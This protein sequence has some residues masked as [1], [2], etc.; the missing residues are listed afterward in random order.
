VVVD[1]W[2]PWCAPCRAFG[3]VLAAASERHPEV[4]FARI[5]SDQEKDLRR[6]FEVESL[7]TLVVVRDHVLLLNRPGYVDAKA[8]DRLVS[9]ALE[10]DLEVVRHGSGQ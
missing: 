2:A 6:A 3:P 4:G 5:D 10:V 9:D 1:F 8:L 7:P